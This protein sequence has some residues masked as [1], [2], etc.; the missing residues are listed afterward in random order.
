LRSRLL[1]SLRLDREDGQA[2]PLFAAAIGALL[3][4]A[5]VVVDGG[6]LFQNRQSLQNA[7]D[8]AAALPLIS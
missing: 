6:N 5:G 7:A 4:M 8:A 2:L 3:L 1:A